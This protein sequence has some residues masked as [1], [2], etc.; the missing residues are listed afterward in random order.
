MQQHHHPYGRNDS[1][2]SA[3]A[4]S[5]SSASPTSSVPEMTPTSSSCGTGSYESSPVSSY[6][7]AALPSTTQ[8]SSISRSETYTVGTTPTTTTAA[9]PPTTSPDFPPPSNSSYVFNDTSTEVG[10][11]GSHS[12]TSSYV[13]PSGLTEVERKVPSSLLRP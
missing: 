7:P 3:T 11:T 9:A 6:P 13:L 5:K 1:V 8:Q 12:Y 2:S 10:G 4:Y